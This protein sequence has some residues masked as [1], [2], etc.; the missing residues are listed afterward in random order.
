MAIPK[1]H[2][3]LDPMTLNILPFLLFFKCLFTVF[4]ESVIRRRFV[5]AMPKG[6]SYR[7]TGFEI[8]PSAGNCSYLLWLI[9]VKTEKVYR[10][11]LFAEF[12]K[13]SSF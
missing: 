3:I 2:S 13:K 9:P 12:L 6:K 4:N 5:D 7:M 8:L 10:E 11:L 1:W